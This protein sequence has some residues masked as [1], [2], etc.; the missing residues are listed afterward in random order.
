MKRLQ[1]F[2][3]F[4]CTSLCMFTQSFDL[5]VKC[6]DNENIPIESVAISLFQK[7]ELVV[8]KYSDSIGTANVKLSH[9]GM[10]QIKL[11][12]FG[13][14]E[15]DT[16]VE[17]KLQMHNIIFV[18]AT[19]DNKIEGVT[20]LA[21]RNPIKTTDS[22]LNIEVNGSN[23]LGNNVANI[24]KNSPGIDINDNSI[25]LFGKKVLVLKDGRPTNLNGKQLINSLTNKKASGIERIELIVS[26]DSKMDA[27]FDGRI[28]NIISYKREGDGYEY[29]LFTDLNRNRDYFSPSLSNDFHIKRG[30]NSYY[31]EIGL[32]NSNRVERINE[33]RSIASDI[34]LKINSNDRTDNNDFGLSSEFGWDHYL[35]EKNIFGFKLDYSKEQELAKSTNL[36]I[37][38]SNDSTFV[39][40]TKNK[41]K[42]NFGN[43]NLNYKYILDNK[44]GEVNIDADYGF[45]NGNY[46]SDQS[47]DIDKNNQNRVSDSSNQLLD[48][49]NKI[50]AL[51]VD[52]TR[53]VGEINFSYGGK[54]LNNQSRQ[55]TDERIIKN[56]FFTDNSNYNERIMGI[57]LNLKYKCKIITLDG[58]LRSENTNYNGVSDVAGTKI[59]NN[60]T[61]LFPHFNVSTKIGKQNLI[62]SYRKLIKRPT[63]QELMPFKRYSSPLYYYVGS[64]SLLPFYPTNLE[65]LLNLNFGLILK[66]NHQFAKNR[67]VDFNRQV[68][69]S[70]VTESVRLNNGKF[71]GNF[72]S[73]NYNK[74]LHTKLNLKSRFNYFNTQQDVDLFTSDKFE[75][76]GY[77]FSITPKIDFTDKIYL[78]T[79]YYYSSEFYTGITKMLPFWYLDLDLHFLMMNESAELII[80]ARDILNKNISRYDLR[81]SNFIETGSNNWSS[82]QLFI[83][84]SYS[85]EKEKLDKKRVRNNTANREII[86]RL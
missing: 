58:G 18:L 85:F 2:I 51:K 70:L 11:Q 31:G 45:K 42:L 29:S 3:L 27:S 63:F 30:K 66:I 38:G 21:T 9:P 15:I 68:P 69:N 56:Y 34:P 5:N 28:I 53:K 46:V 52:A 60:Y 13:F 80:G 75:V 26:S 16:F 84:F 64:P 23:I 61:G 4:M 55:F 20:I 81:Y 25:E 72:I 24:L 40:E 59:N 17:V 57:Y 36:S 37:I 44:L 65:L 12:S 39:S 86:E 10:Y 1:L 22:G 49:K 35:N 50:L 82:Q 7:A 33:Y 76:S 48:L 54:Y 62:I 77:S 41:E 71:S 83:S 32:N 19:L 8:G 67:V 78:N 47:Y 43:I 79:S 73:L 74:K 14:E 6:I